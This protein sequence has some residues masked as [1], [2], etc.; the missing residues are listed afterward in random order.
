MATIISRKA[1]KAPRTQVAAP[2]GVV[3]MGIFRIRR[4]RGLTLAE[5]A[6]RTEL[7]KGYLSRIERGQKSPSIAALL[8]ISEALGVQ[9][10]HLFGE[11][12]AGDAVQI[13]RRQDRTSL[14]G[15]DGSGFINA[16]LPANHG[17]RV[18]A[19]VVEPGDRS[20][21][22]A[23]DHAGDEFLFVLKGRVKIEFPD[24][25]FELEEGDSAY[26]DGHL[27]HQLHRIDSAPAEVLI[28]VAQDLPQQ[29][30]PD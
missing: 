9:V 21:D 1:K 10:G 4:R 13:V 20:R 5:L 17:R 30:V 2:P 29:P 12:T 15:T 3:G 19:F 14:P 11:R 23:A 28:I 27:R 22:T 25:A 26:F 18:S 24:Q 7:D 6:E 8:K 16:I